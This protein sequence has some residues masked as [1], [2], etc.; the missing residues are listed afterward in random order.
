M[1]YTKVF[2]FI[3]LT[4]MEPNWSILYSI[5]TN[6]IFKV[7]FGV[8]MKIKKSQLKKGLFVV[9]VRCKLQSCEQ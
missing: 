7:S 4:T 5:E 3:K 9:T 8:K 6:V 1:I 2:T